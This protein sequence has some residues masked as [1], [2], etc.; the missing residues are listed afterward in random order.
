V[1]GKVASTPRRVCAGAAV[2][3][4]EDLTAGDTTGHRRPSASAAQAAD[5]GGLGR[6]DDTGCVTLRH[7]G[8]LHH[9]GIGRT[10]AV[11]L[12]QDL[13]VHIAN[14]TGELHRELVLQ[15]AGSAVADVMRHSRPGSVFAT[16]WTRLNGLR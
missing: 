10:H 1:G 15:T 7:A 16:S 9:I 14:A 4:A 2:A 12:I 6:V 8:R 13:P 5:R 11:M 3:A